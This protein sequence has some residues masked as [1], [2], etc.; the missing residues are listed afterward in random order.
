VSQLHLHADKGDVAPFVLLPGD[1]DRAT[2][3]AETFF[4]APR[5]YTSYRHLY[6]YTGRYKAMPV[7]V[8]TTGMGCP[9][10]AIVV[11][12]LLRLGAK[13]LV[14]V[15][16]AG[17]ISREVR[18]GELVIATASVPLEGTSAQY[19]RGAPY[20][21]TASFVVTR[22]LVDAAQRLGHNPH[23]GLIQTEDAFYATSPSDVATLAARG[24]LAVEMEASALFT[25]AAL[26]RAQAGCALVASN[27]IGDP[28]FV[29]ADV[30]RQSVHAMAEMAL[31]AGLE[32]F[33]R[34]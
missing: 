22:A 30:L 7:S 19:L 9:S 28:E 17:I 24:V 18:P 29:A 32:L 15:G 2:Y 26:R 8:Q 5:R 27:Y 1:P 34:G 16:T 21:P 3:I 14:R 4:E 12:E 10:L 6:G 33:Q 25:L 31:E 23:V 20:A 13:T 11:E